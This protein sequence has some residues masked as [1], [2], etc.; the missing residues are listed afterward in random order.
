[1]STDYRKL[2]TDPIAHEMW[3][4]S[5]CRM[6]YE[7]LTETQNQPY[8]FA[9]WLKNSQTVQ[10]LVLV[11]WGKTNLIELVYLF[12]INEIINDIND[13]VINY[14]KKVAYDNL[15]VNSLDTKIHYDLSIDNYFIDLLKTELNIDHNDFST[16]KLL[17][18]YFK[19]K[20]ISVTSPLG[21]IL[22]CLN[23]N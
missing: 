11:I 4:L 20:N 14:I 13:I 3:T 17:S 5:E 1:M 18:Q 22:N 2:I 19:S 10:T 16:A 9:Y 12:I 21:Y 15:L 7:M 8:E 6:A 23:I